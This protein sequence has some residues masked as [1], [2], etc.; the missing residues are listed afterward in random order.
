MDTTQPLKIWWETDQFTNDLPIP[1]Q[2]I[3]YAGPQSI[4]AVRAFEDGKTDRGWGADTFMDLYNGRKFTTARVIP[5]FLREVWQFA[6]IMRSMRLV[7]IDIDGK[8]NGFN[9]LRSLLPLPETL[10]EVSKSGNGLHLFYSVPDVW[11]DKLGFSAFAD[12]IGLVEGVDIRA[13]GCVYHHAQQRWND[14]EIAPLPAHLIS[15]L[16][17]YAEKI[18]AQKSRITTIL[19]TTEEHEVL[20]MQD[21]LKSQLAEPIPAGRRNNTLFA[22]G[23]QMKLAQ[24]E[25]WSELVHARALAVG[26]SGEEADKL[27]GNISTYA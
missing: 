26:L 6:F 18:S 27:V 13:T 3:D 14:R 15:K 19:N 12:R 10:A 23:S 22:I 2:F 21:D 20:M 7:C 8:N 11:D 16:T 25:G 5:G 1:E 4:A 17:A 24:I 9:G